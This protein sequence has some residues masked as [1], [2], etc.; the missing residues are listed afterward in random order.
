[1]L[2]KSSRSCGMSKTKALC[3]KVGA[4]SRPIS[5]R[6]TLRCGVGVRSWV[7]EHE[8]Q[9][10]VAAGGLQSVAPASVRG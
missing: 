8:G 7:G 6:C 10:C 9:P 2:P 5:K 1:M 4:S 3:A